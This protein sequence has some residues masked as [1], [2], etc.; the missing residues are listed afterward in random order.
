MGYSKDE[1]KEV[2]CHNCGFWM[3]VR[4]GSNGNAKCDE[5][6]EPLKY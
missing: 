2:Q 1:E 3:T 4:P 6:R 5:C